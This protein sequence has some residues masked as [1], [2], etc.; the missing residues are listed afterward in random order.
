MDK[1]KKYQTI[2]VNFFEA[3]AQQP[4]HNAPALE[5]QVIADLE[6]NHFQLVSLGW[7]NRKFTHDT[8][9]HLDIKDGKIWIQQ[10]WTDIQIADE[11]IKRGVEKTDIVLGFV[12]PYAREYTGFAVA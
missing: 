4:Y 12:P 1:I 10:N 8:I 2:I 9:F 3:Y 6:R 5:Q 11:L 7:D